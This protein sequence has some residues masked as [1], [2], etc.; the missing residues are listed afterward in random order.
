ELRA[1]SVNPIQGS[2][3][4]ANIDPGLMG[5]LTMRAI[6]VV[7]SSIVLFAICADGVRAQQPAGVPP[8]G[9]ARSLISIDFGG[10]RLS[11]YVSGLRQRQPG[12]NVVLDSLVREIPVPAISL[13]AVTF[14]TALQVIPATE[15]ARE[16]G[17]TVQKAGN[18][19]FIVQSTR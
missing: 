9:E 6:A 18:E 10:G 12:V 11:D 13:Q 14:A 8:L 5:G 7:A 19:V 4:S 1:A 3:M 16:L 17:V 15:A 2:R